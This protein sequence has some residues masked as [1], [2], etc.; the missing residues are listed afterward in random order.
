VLSYEL[1]I[2]G[3]PLIVDSGTYAYTFD[4][5]ARNGFRSTRAHNTIAVDDAE[6]HPIDPTRV[7][8]LRPFARPTIGACDLDGDPLELVGSHNGYRRLYQP[9][10]HRRCFSLA[11]A[12]EKLTVRDKLEGR[13]EH[14]LESFL[15]LAPGV[16]ARRVADTVIEVESGPARARI[17]FHRVEAGELEAE[18][19]WVSD[20]YGVRERAPLLVARARRTCPASF[21]YEIAPAR[22][23]R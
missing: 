21:G 3:V 14:V 18:Q 11:V 1:S 2:D 10:V 17:S 5:D 16:L 15:H 4:V 13:G 20:R 22:L 7:F 12:T 8:E 23:R 6:I 19:D 9:I